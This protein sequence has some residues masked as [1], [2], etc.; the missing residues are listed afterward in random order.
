MPARQRSM[1]RGGGGGSNPG[2]GHSHNSF[3]H[4]PPPP[5]PPPTFPV[6]AMPPNGYSNL[7]PT[8][9]DQSPREPLNRGNN[10]EPR[11]A[12]GFVVSDHRHSSRRGNFGPRGD[13]PYH[14]N[15]GGRRDQ[16]RGHYGNVRDVHV[17]PQRAPPRGFVRPPPL[18]TATFVPPQQVRPFANPMG[19]PGKLFSNEAVYSFIVDLELMLLLS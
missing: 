17:Q 6:F 4:P 10:W 12:G 14:N 18:N 11:A 8:M 2:G 9:P 15:F 7:V 3:A 1:K 19:F 16:D 13:G 5:P